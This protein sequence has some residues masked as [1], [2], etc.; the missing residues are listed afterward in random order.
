MT[1]KISDFF[2]D[3]GGFITGILI[4]AIVVLCNIIDIIV[5][6]AVVLG[7]GFLGAYVQKNK[8]SVKEKLK[9]QID[10]W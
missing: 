9:K 2:K 1:E 8:S 4:G 7:F 10:K 3:F 6:I 5:T